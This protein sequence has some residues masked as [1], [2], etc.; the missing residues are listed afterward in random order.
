LALNADQVNAPQTVAPGWLHFVVRHVR[1][2]EGLLPLTLTWVAL[3]CLP[4]V[5]I[6]GELI[7]GLAP[8]LWLT[9]LGMLAAWWL[10]HRRLN[11]FIAAPVLAIGGIVADLLWGVHVLAFWPLPLQSIGWLYWVATCGI[12]THCTAA[13]PAFTYWGDQAASLAEFAQRVD[14]WWTGLRTGQG[15]ADNLVL[16]GAAGLLAWLVGAWAGWWVPRHSKPFVALFPAGVLLLQTIFATDN[17]NGWILIYLGA[18]GLLLALTHFDWQARRWDADGVDYSSELR[19]ELGLITVLI[20]SLA[21]VLAPLLPFLTSTDFSRLFWDRFEKPYTDIAQNVSHSLPGVQTK[22]SLMPAVHA[23]I[24]GLPRSHLLGGRPD[25]A[26]KVAFRAQ[27][28]GARPGDVLRWRGQTFAIYNGRGWVSDSSQGPGQ[29][30]SRNLPAGQPWLDV[31]PAARHPVLAAIQLYDA[32]RSVLYSPGEPVSVDQPYTAL[33]R[34][35]GELAALQARSLPTRY[36]VL[37]DVPDMDAPLLRGAGTAYP[38]DIR[39]LYLNL[40]DSVPTQVYEMAKRLT[41]GAATPYD[42]ALAI[43][44][45]LRALP[46][47]LDVPAP[48]AGVEVSSWFLFTERQGYC[49]YFATAMAVLARAAGIP[50]R[51]AVGYATGNFDQRTQTYTVT[52]LQAHSWPELYFPNYGWIPFEPTPSET[53]LIRQ[54]ADLPAY[55]YAPTPPPMDSFESQL[56]ELRQ[57]AQEQSI[58]NARLA[59]VQ[60]AL[61]ALGALLILGTTWRWLR[62]EPSGPLTGPAAWYDEMAR[63]GERLGRP[64]QPSETPR[65]YAA[66]LVA[67]AAHVEEFR[68]NGDGAAHAAAVVEAQVPALTAAYE[69]SS[70]APPQETP[71]LT[72][73]AR[74]RAANEEKRRWQALWAALRRLWVAMRLRV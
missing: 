12:H 1:P 35:P 74:Q 5:A 26:G 52:E 60:R 58:E 66:A 22:R 48:P 32:S 44:K 56:S 45:A 54:N 34:D 10:A 25:L 68:K 43:E 21:L 63:W 55:N 59:W 36:T 37:A 42:A 57:L 8:A 65:E 31:Q 71:D 40:P 13:A 9:T 61:F 20:V 29:Y 18:L 33:T 2:R 7:A 15:V 49:D 41:A 30:V 16:I 47:T 17:N 46:Y 38:D 27:L 69:L 50:S 24:P 53:E 64:P 51:L 28:R 70:F 62:R 73:N 3:L 14:W 67:A 6:E 19:L 39:Q 72:P 23:A 11:G 4:A